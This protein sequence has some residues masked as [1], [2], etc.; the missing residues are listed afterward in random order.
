M[1]SD[2]KRAAFG[3]TFAVWL[4]AFSLAAVLAYDLKRPLRGLHSLFSP[5]SPAVTAVTAPPTP[6]ATAGASTSSV[7]YMP[8]VTIVG[9]RPCPASAGPAAPFSTRPEM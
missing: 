1:A 2:K 7:L 5:V 9:T 6:P 8:V 3:L 4:A